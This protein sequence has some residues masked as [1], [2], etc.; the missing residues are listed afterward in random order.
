MRKL[1]AIAGLLLIAAGVLV[2]LA[3]KPGPVS[4][5]TFQTLT[6]P[7]NNRAIA[8]P[9]GDKGYLIIA[10]DTLLK[11]SA[12]QVFTDH[13]RKLGYNV[14]T[15]SVEEIEKKYNTGELADRIRQHLKDNADRLGLRYVLLIGDP[16]PADLRV[17]LPVMTDMPPY[18]VSSPSRS[19]GGT[20]A[21]DKH[22][23]EIASEGRDRVVI[24]TGPNL[25]V[26]RPGILRF[27]YINCTTP[28]KVALRVFR[29]KEN[30][31]H[32]IYAGE[33]ESVSC[34]GMAVRATKPVQIEAGDFIG[35]LL[36][37]EG[38]AKVAAVS[39]P[40][41]VNARYNDS[42]YRDGN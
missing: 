32:S 11:L 23:G 22:D 34:P 26:L 20:Y 19:L 30:S 40:G 8:F 16:D 3:F 1:F 21:S 24:L 17:K 6:R 33:L 12:V 36:P 7:S 31:Y 9:A 42:D 18:V 39:T 38:A 13:K 29:R 37:A 14:E 27:W 41:E 4:D 5:A 28:G 10:P 2:F 35:F 25:Q 15:V